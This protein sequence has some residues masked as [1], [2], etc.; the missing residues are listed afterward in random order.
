MGRCS[1]WHVLAILD[2]A[3]VISALPQTNCL[4]F[5]LHLPQLVYIRMPPA[6]CLLPVGHISLLTPISSTP[7]LL[8]AREHLRMM[9]TSTH[10]LRRHW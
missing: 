1:R 10:D 7:V 8:D 3:A 6:P 2:N 4:A 9:N 5:F